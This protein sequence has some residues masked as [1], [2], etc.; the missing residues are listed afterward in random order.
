MLPLLLYQNTGSVS[1]SLS[2]SRQSVRLY[3]LCIASLSEDLTPLPPRL[4]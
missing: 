1:L 4:K 2:A 3:K